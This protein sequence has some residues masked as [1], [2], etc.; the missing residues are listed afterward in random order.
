MASPVTAQ[1]ATDSPTTEDDVPYIY[2]Y[3]NV[4]NGIVIERA[5]GTD[6]RIIG[7]GLVDED[8]AAIYGPGWSPDGRWVLT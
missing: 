6:S 7:Q 2:Y 3:S 1:E 5:D 4:L 8:V